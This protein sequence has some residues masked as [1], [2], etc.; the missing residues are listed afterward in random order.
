[1]NLIGYVGYDSDRTAAEQQLQRRVRQAELALAQ[2]K[3]LQ[4]PQAP[5]VFTEKWC[6]FRY[7]SLFTSTA[8]PDESKQRDRL[9]RLIHR[10][11]EVDKAA[12]PRSPD[13]GSTKQPANAPSAPQAA[14]CG[15]QSRQ[16]PDELSMLQASPSPG[17]RHGLHGSGSPEFHQRV[18]AIRFRLQAMP[19]APEGLQEEDMSQEKADCRN[20]ILLSQMPIL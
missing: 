1:M 20:L 12:S 10:G 16:S 13:F 3:T 15:P 18:D 6:G 2:A 5:K 4:A 7:S 17:F 9:I 14:P 11:A 8:A 19:Q